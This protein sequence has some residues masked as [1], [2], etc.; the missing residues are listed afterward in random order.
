MI[1]DELFVERKIIEA[2]KYYQ[3]AILLRPNDRYVIGQIKKIED[4]LNSQSYKEERYLEIIDKG[5][6]LFRK[7]KFDD[8]LVEFNKALEVIPN[9]AYA[10]GKIYKIIE[11]KESETESVEE[12]NNIMSTGITLLDLN[13]FTEAIKSFKKAAKLLPDN[14]APDVYIAKAKEARINFETKL[15]A[16]SKEIELAS[17]YIETEEY[18]RTLTHLKN[19]QDILPDN[20]A[21]AN[22]IKNFTLLANQPQIENTIGEIKSK[23]LDLQFSEQVQNSTLQIQYKEIVLDERSIK[24]D[25]IPHKPL[26]NIVNNNVP[27]II[28]Q[29][30]IDTIIK[31]NKKE[32]GAI[33]ANL[34]KLKEID[35]EY[36]NKMVD[37]QNLFNNDQFHEARISFKIASQIKPF[38]VKPNMYIARIDSIIKLQ[39]IQ[40]QIDQKYHSAINTGDSLLEINLF[41]KSI[42]AFTIAYSIKPGDTLASHKLHIAQNKKRD[43]NLAIQIMKEYNEAVKVGDELLAEEKYLLSKIAYEKALTIK[44]DKAYP[45]VKVK[46]IVRILAKIDF[47]RNQ[48]Y[49]KAITAADKLYNSSDLIQALVQ[50]KIALDIKTEEN[51][52]KNKIAEIN[53]LIE[54][55]LKQIKEKYDLT[56]ANADKL[57][58]IKI[59]DKAIDSYREAS[60]ILQTETYP[61]EMISKIITLIEENA[62]VDIFNDTLTIKAETTRTFNFEPVSINVRRSSY[63]FF[64]AVNLS[65]NPFKLI[66]SYGSDKGKNGG[67]VVIAAEGIEKNDYVIRVG[68]QYKWFAD[69]NNWISIYPEKGDIQLSMMQIS[70]SN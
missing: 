26:L 46:E 42:A 58:A 2:R 64:K 3:T 38:E 44:P 25:L 70:K 27:P 67:F 12:F 61:K 13:K 1:G 40:K 14:T 51:Y 48:K 18:S 8:A 43:Y 17:K 59:Y 66:V 9:D 49:N 19:A 39:E 54:E 57:Y 69:D 63:I 50:Y 21:L 33:K 68:N 34:E 62:I 37:A 35:T 10:L 41:D 30:E 16:Y 47:D 4:E 23:Q 28:K 52:P 6:A 55:E 32:I 24:P 22:E 11:I 7:Y 36:N 20:W 31:Y 45:A 60:N 53:T 29:S 15:T 5:D 65:T 56:I